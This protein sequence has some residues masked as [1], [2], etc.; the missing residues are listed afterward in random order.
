MATDTQRLA[1]RS[2]PCVTWEHLE[3]KFRFPDCIVT[4][5]DPDKLKCDCG[6]LKCVHV[7]Y[8]RSVLEE[9]DVFDGAD[10]GPYAEDAREAYNDVVFGI[11][12]ILMIPSQ[13]LPHWA[14]ALLEV[15][16][17]GD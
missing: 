4:G 3:N 12:M 15:E 16:K 13:A 9:C 7:A 2:L 6:M 5:F 17:D 14:E 1:L 11:A 10:A 8:I